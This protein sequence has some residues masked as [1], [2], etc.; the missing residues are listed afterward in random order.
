MYLTAN[1]CELSKIILVYTQLGGSFK[2]RMSPCP[3]EKVFME[4]KS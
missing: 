2:Q 4:K 3:W 1:N